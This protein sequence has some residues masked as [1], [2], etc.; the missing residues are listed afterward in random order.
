MAVVPP[1]VVSLI[2]MKWTFYGSKVRSYRK[3]RDLQAMEINVG[4]SVVSSLTNDVD[5]DLFRV[6]LAYGE[7][8]KFYVTSNPSMV[9][10]ILSRIWIRF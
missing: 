1:T 9:Y 10:L 2:F 6:S 7:E 5:A 4:D 3:W 8:Y